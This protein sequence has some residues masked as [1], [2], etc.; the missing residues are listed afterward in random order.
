MPLTIIVPPASEPVTLAEAKL[1]LRVDSSSEDSMISMLITSAR[2]QAEAMTGRQLMPATI[3]MTM[4]YFPCAR[5]MDS[6]IG[7]SLPGNAIIFQVAPVTA[8]NSVQYLDQSQVWRTI[9]PNDYVVDLASDSAR[10]HLRFGAVWPIPAQQIGSVR[11]EFDAGY[12]NAAAVPTPIKQWI[13]MTTSSGYS[14]REGVT[15]K[16]MAMTPFLAGLLDPYK[17]MAL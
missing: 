6:G 16:Q 10:I 8:V 9:D 12:A 14:Q 7:F 15:A 11:V 3:L 5:T 17:V 13:L 1:H 2:M 4:D